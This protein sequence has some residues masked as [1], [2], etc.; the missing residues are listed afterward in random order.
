MCLF[1]PCPSGSDLQSC[2]SHLKKD[3][4]C[5]CCAPKRQ[6]S[7]RTACR[8]PQSRPGKPAGW[9][10]RSHSTSR[11]WRVKGDVVKKK[12]KKRFIV[13]RQHA[14]LA[15]LW[16]K[17][18]VPLL[19]LKIPVMTFR[20][21]T[22]L[23]T[24]EE[25]GLGPKV[26]RPTCRCSCTP[27][28][29]TPWLEEASASCPPGGSA[30]GADWPPAPSR[31]PCWWQSSGWAPLSS[32]AAALAPTWGKTGWR[33]RLPLG[34]FPPQRSRGSIRPLER[35]SRPLTFVWMWCGQRIKSTN[36]WWERQEAPEE[37]RECNWWRPHSGSASAGPW[38]PL[39]EIRSCHGS[40]IHKRAAPGKCRNS[41]RK[42]QT[43]SLTRQLIIQFTQ[44]LLW[45]PRIVTESL[46]YTGRLMTSAE[47]SSETPA[48]LR[49]PTLG[50]V[51]HMR[52]IISKVS[53]KKHKV[54]R[55]EKSLQ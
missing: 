43:K 8:C 20:A 10:S 9:C 51:S 54:W 14:L 49:P 36:L 24:W 47:S 37:F 23:A 31:R 2:W 44:F 35:Q 15:C 5:F 17:L 42:I 6:R 34:L 45:N 28:S 12:K 29:R 11:S 55:K 27:Q 4:W 22:T 1:S 48:L 25:L 41:C 19:L 53:K 26:P 52:S 40:R 7:D 33:R 21:R 3:T 13:K 39:A 30:P 16:L 18:I 38:W 50:G 46:M 32:V